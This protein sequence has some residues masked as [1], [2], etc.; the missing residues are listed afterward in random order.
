MK[1][2]RIYW[3]DMLRGFCILAILW[4]HTEMYYAGTDM[5]PYA[6][7]VG[8]VLAIF[9]FLSGYVSY[10]RSPFNVRGMLYGVCRWLLVPYLVFTSLAALPK[11]IVHHS[12]DGILPIVGDIISGQASWF[13]F[14]LI[15][16]KLL[17]IGVTYVLGT[18]TAVLTLSG[19]LALV[20]AG[21]VG[22]AESQWYSG[23]DGFCVN[24]AMLG[25]AVMI[26]G[27]LFWRYEALAKRYLFHL[28][29]CSALFL[30]AALSKY[31][32][33]HSCLRMVFGP[34]IVSNFPLFLFDLTVMALLLAGIFM[35]MPRLRM[36]EWIGRRS[37]V[38]YFFCGGCP[39]LISM[40]LE[41]VG[42][43]YIHYLQIPV[44]FA[45]VVV[46]TS[47][48]VWLVYRYTSIVRRP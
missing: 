18:S 26:A 7:Y 37:I 45:C 25:Y 22:N 39:L 11:A 34:V 1:D 48:L 12:F 32:L 30:L 47:A 19:I 21:T 16:A 31:Y 46:F 14:S 35:R 42:L 41:K 36:L 40:A 28:P 4:F 17:F 44:V 15:V 9:F 23:F 20:W 2:N 3:V 5:I 10:R 13:V 38:Y 33:Y 27:F 43:P 24:E 29:G 6:M 8:N